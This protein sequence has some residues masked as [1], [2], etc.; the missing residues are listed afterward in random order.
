[1]AWDLP[2]GRA[3]TG[4]AADD[5]S[6]DA[7]LTRSMQLS[8][9]LAERHC[10][11][12]FLLADE[13]ESVSWPGARIPL[14]RYPVETI[15]KVTLDRAGLSPFRLDYDLDHDAGMVA[16]RH[17]VSETRLFFH[18]VGGYETLPVDLDEALW[19][20]FASIWDEQYGD[21]GDDGGLV[22]ADSGLVKSI[23][24]FGVGS[25]TYEEAPS[26][27]GT[28]GA[29][30]AMFVQPSTRLAWVLDSYARPQV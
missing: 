6:R 1:M 30:A 12:A 16:L 14:R 25:V 26:V 28:V 13:V 10:G 2:T 22:T 19:A 5:T 7:D 27:A 24:L 18:Y 11:R 3:R 21:T 15:A 20:I 17:H 29:S 4:L 23:T 8:L 9:A